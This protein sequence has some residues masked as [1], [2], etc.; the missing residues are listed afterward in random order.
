MA[1]RQVVVEEVVFNSY[2]EAV[3]VKEHAEMQIETIAGCKIIARIGT[4][5]GVA[6]FLFLYANFAS[7]VQMI[8]VASSCICYAKAKCFSRAFQWGL[9]WAKWGWFLV[10]YFPIDLVIGAC[11]LFAGA[12]AFFFFPSL[13]LRGVEKQAQKD[14]DDANLF[15]NEYQMQT[16][17]QIN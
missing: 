16:Q 4:I 14:L 11:G 2:Q 3:N 1:R 9:S 6:S 12:I 17:T 5:F 7:I 10:P 8:A 15:I 13:G